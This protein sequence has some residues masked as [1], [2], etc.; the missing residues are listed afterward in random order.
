MTK[1]PSG[2]TKKTPSFFPEQ[3]LGELRSILVE[4]FGRDVKD[5]AKLQEIGLRLVELVAIKER[6]NLQDRAI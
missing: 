2:K 1:T 3:L 4:D 6:S 5:G